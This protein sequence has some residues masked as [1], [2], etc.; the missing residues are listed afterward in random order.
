MLMA[1]IKTGLTNLYKVGV[2]INIPMVYLWNIMFQFK[3]DKAIA[4]IRNKIVIIGIA[5]GGYK[6]TLANNISK[7]HGHTHI[8]IDM[9]I[10]GENWKR[11]T[12]E[13]FKQ[14]VYNEIKKSN[15]YYVIDG[16]YSDSSRM[17]EYQE[18]MDEIIKRADIVICLNVP[19]VI[20]IWRKL[21]RSF[22]RAMGVTG[23]ESCPEKLHNVIA[24]LKKTWNHY[25][26]KYKTLNDMWCKQS[27]KKY[28]RA[29]WP[30]YIS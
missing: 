2:M 1:I 7:K 19:K 30:C 9:C 11:H 8:R 23:D 29:N 25:D 4:N 13:Q 22:K 15:G 20:Y 10:Y 21:F 24:M 16:L 5:G 18:V 27:D 14:N 26:T 12:P 17:K 28:I 3:F 6:T